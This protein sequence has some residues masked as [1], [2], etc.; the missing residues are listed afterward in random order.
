MRWRGKAV[1]IVSRPK[2]R[3]LTVL[4]A[5]DAKIFRHAAEAERLDVDSRPADL[6]SEFV[7]GGVRDACSYSRAI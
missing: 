1:Q 5:R 2:I 6:R 3:S 4:K 7:G